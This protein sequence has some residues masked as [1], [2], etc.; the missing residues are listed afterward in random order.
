MKK[1]ARILT[2]LGA[3]AVFGGCAS[4]PG[5][6]DRVVSRSD[7]LKERPAWAKM[8]DSGYA[9]TIGKDGTVK[10]G[11]SGSGERYFCS[12]GIFN[13]PARKSTNIAQLMKAAE[14]DSKA[15]VIASLETKMQESVE[16][17]AEGFEG[18]T[19]VMRNTINS[20]SKGVLRGI[21]VA[22]K[23]WEKKIVNT[24][25]GQSFQYDVYVLSYISE[26]DLQESID[27]MAKKTHLSPETKELLNKGRDY[28]FSEN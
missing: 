7:D 11:L 21:R 6:E 23:Y 27:A 20:A 24:E 12:L 8:G 9:C 22:K 5:V 1:S 16:K 3:I 19:T 18:D 10:S 15:A 26:K 2:V 14:T 13:R 28:V 25:D 17:A 4:I